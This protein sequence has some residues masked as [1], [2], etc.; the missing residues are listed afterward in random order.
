[1]KQKNKLI[2]TIF[3]LIS[4]ISLCIVFPVISFCEEDIGG[5]YDDTY[6]AIEDAEGIGGA[7]GVNENTENTD[8]TADTENA[9]EDEANLYGEIFGMVSEKSSEIL[10]ALTFIG[11]LILM[12]SYKK[13]LI[14]IIK[15]ALAA[16]GSKVKSIGERSESFEENMKGT[17][18]ELSSKLSDAEKVLSKLENALEEMK[19]ESEEKKRMQK[20][21]IALKTVLLTEIEM[22]YEIFMSASLPQY[23]KDRIGEKISVMKSKISESETEN[24]GEN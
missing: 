16:L 4:A 24:E 11:S 22:L 10:S 15:D 3:V 7:A 21:S 1:M 17:A 13:G 14:P 20:D 5:G 9:S 19:A 2:K 23:L 8:D 12:L 6:E 18:E